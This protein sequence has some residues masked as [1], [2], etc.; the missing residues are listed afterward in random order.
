MLYTSICRP[1]LF[2]YGVWDHVRMNQG[3]VDSDALCSGKMAHIHCNLN[4]APYLQSTLNQVTV[5][6]H[7]R[8]T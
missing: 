1:I 6:L 5:Y 7:A 2:Q 4:H 8:Y 3:K